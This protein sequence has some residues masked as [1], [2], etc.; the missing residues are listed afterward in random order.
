MLGKKC[1]KILQDRDEPCAFCTNDRIF[2]EY[3]GRSYVWESQNEVTKCWYRCADKAIRETHGN[4]PVIIVT[5]YPDSEL[6]SQ[7]LE[8]GPLLIL[9]KPVDKRHLLEGIL[10]ALRVPKST[11][12]RG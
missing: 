4:V 3:L 11:R 6:L 5:G 2:G 8:N 1:Y 7:A 12:Q 9:A 10:T